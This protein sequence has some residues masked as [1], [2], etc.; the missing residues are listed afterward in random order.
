[1]ND[2][3][4]T[5][6]E[7]LKMKEDFESSKSKQQ[8]KTIKPKKT[9]KELGA[10][11]EFGLTTIAT[12]D[13]RPP[14]TTLLI[15]SPAVYSRFDREGSNTITRLL[16]GK[17]YTTTAS[18][19]FE[20]ETE[21]SL[22][23][24][25]LGKINNESLKARKDVTCIKMEFS[26]I[27][28]LPFIA[29]KKYRKRFNQE[30]IQ[31]YLEAKQRYRNEEGFSIFDMTDYISSNI[32][33]VNDAFIHLF[34]MK[35]RDIVIDCTVEDPDTGE[36]IRDLNFNICSAVD[37]N[38]EEETVSFHISPMLGNSIRYVGSTKF[39]SISFINKLTEWERSLFFFLEDN[40]EGV[41]RSFYLS[42]FKAKTK[43][44]LDEEKVN[45]RKIVA[46]LK[47]LEKLGHITIPKPYEI[48]KNK[49]TKFWF[50]KVKRES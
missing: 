38:Y 49:N 22:F 43:L 8:T 11:T 46:A 12:S 20:N 30:E 26:E 1:M 19:H 31:L 2:K 41:V 4:I 18:N 29:S 39:P 13:D 16:N 32:K 10:G 14:I 7:M 36:F 15:H 34:A 28:S 3:N 23:L 33:K 21:I 6:T 5:L 27:D 45:R 47:K 24:T 44:E 35:M 42:E 17:K 37:F 40:Q 9:F 50:K 25:L 48:T